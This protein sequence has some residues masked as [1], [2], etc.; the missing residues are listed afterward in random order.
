[1][2]IHLTPAASAGQANEVLDTSTPHAAE[3][4]DDL[5]TLQVELFVRNELDYLAGVKTWQRVRDVLDVGC[6]NGA[7]LARLRA[8]FPDKTYCG[9]DQS[10]ELIA[11]ADTAHGGSGIDFVHGDYFE[12]GEDRSYDAILMRFVVQHLTDLEAILGKS[13]ALLKPGGSLFITEPSLAA[14]FN[15]P[16]TPFFMGLLR[17]FEADAEAKG[18]LRRQLHDPP[19]LTVSHPDWVIAE[20]TTLAVINRGPFAGH[21]L[22]A[23]YGKWIDLC[24]GAA[25]V[26]YPYDQVRAEIAAWST[27]PD[28]L[29]HVALRVLRLQLRSRLSSDFAALAPSVD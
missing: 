5:L 13:A 3:R 23:L 8:A 12:V 14:S 27:N 7:F 20:D 28:A 2:N 16:E 1:M 19:A 22:A 26:A 4:W 25:G 10:A 24:E 29:S 18:R 21:P 15:C 9:L 11:A 6:G 17:A